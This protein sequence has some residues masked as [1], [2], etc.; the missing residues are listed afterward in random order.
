MRLLF[1]EPKC[2]WS[3]TKLALVQTTRE[4]IKHRPKQART[5]RKSQQIWLLIF[6]CEFPK[7][8]VDLQTICA[9]E[10]LTEGQW[11]EGQQNI[12]TFLM[13][14]RATRVPAASKGMEQSLAPVKK[15]VKNKAQEWRRLF[16]SVCKYN[17]YNKLSFL[18]CSCT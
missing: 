16:C 8:Y 2:L 1:S 15:F 18:L 11:L 6:K 13:F 5:K 17:F 3:V 10:I 4:I 7:V 14:Q 12:V 9:A